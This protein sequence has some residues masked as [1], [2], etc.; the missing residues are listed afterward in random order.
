M[1]DIKTV[2]RWSAYEHEHVERSTDWYWALGIAAVSVAITSI[3]FQSFLF[4]LLILL[5][6]GTYALMAQTPPQMAQFEIS[7][8]GIRINDELHRYQ[9]VI[10]FWVED[11]HHGKAQLLIDTTKWF[12]PNLVIPIEHIDPSVIRAFLKERVKERYMKESPAH[13][14]LEFFGL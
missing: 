11:D 2:L 13:R 5:A 4:A 10:A 12:S 9:E 1:E 6:A 14:A 3:L 8:K 7:E